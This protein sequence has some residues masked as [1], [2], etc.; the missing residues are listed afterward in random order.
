MERQGYDLQLSRY[1]GTRRGGM[2]MPDLTEMAAMA[3]HQ[4]RETFERLAAELNETE[5]GFRLLKDRDE[6]DATARLRGAC[7]WLIDVFMRQEQELAQ[8]RTKLQMILARLQ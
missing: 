3:M 1:R 5:A 4:V 7:S 2:T 6:K 8:M